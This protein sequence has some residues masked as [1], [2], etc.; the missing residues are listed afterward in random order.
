MLVGSLGNKM[1]SRCVIVC[2][3]GLARIPM[4]T[5]I[6]FVYCC[7]NGGVP[8]RVNFFGECLSYMEIVPFMGKRVWFYVGVLLIFLLGGRYR[9]VLFSSCGHGNTTKLGRGSSPIATIREINVL[10][11]LIPFLTVGSAF[12]DVL[13][14]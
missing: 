5:I 9:I 4:L 14:G 12:M 11:F 8:P 13:V 6:W 2:K 10:V 1:G 7:T 3:G